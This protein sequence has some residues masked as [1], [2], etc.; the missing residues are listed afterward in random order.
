MSKNCDAVVMFSIYGRFGA[1]RKP[2]SRRI[3]CKTYVFISSSRLSY[4]T[5]SRTK[6]FLTQLSHYCLEQRYY[7]C[8][9]MLT[10][11]QKNAD[12]SKI[13]RELVRKGIFS[14]TTNV[15]TYVSNFKFLA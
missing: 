9:K 12:M 8:Q 6:K 13:K 2:D 7:F 11:L 1:I 3:V 14:E 5:E 4:K 15:C 10:F